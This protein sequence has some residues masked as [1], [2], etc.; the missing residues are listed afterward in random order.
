MEKANKAAF[1][2]MTPFAS[3]MHGGL[4]S[5]LNQDALVYVGAYD[6]YAKKPISNKYIPTKYGYAQSHVKVEI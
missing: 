5:A 4:T 1:R 3:G 2:S 6:A